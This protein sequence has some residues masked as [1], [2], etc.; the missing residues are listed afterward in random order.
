[1]H[2]ITEALEDQRNRVLRNAAGGMCHYLNTHLMNLGGS[3]DDLAEELKALNDL[4]ERF[5]KGEKS[6]IFWSR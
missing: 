5:A 3:K 1:M 2:N 4:I 6:R